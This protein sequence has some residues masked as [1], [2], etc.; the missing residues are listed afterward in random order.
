LLFSLWIK[1][2]S[3]GANPT[4][5]SYNTSAVKS[6]SATKSIARLYVEQK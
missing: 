1:L 4:I 5:M 6:Y 3:T 2:H